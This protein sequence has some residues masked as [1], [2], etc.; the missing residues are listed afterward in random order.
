MKR[1]NRKIERKR[2]RERNKE[3]KKKQ[4]KRERHYMNNNW[5]AMM[6]SG[7]NVHENEDIKREKKESNERD[8]SWEGEREHDG[9]RENKPQRQHE[10]VWYFEH[11]MTLY[12]KWADTDDYTTLIRFHSL[13]LSPPLTISFN[14][15][16]SLIFSLFH[17]SI[18]TLPLTLLTNSVFVHGA[19]LCTFILILFTICMNRERESN[20][21]WMMPWSDIQVRFPFSLSCFSPWRER[22]SFFL[23]HS[24]FTRSAIGYKWF[25]DSGS[26]RMSLRCILSQSGFSLSPFNSVPSFPLL[27][28]FS[29]LYSSLYFF[30]SI[31]GRKVKGEE[32]CFEYRMIVCSYACNMYGQ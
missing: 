14:L 7:P 21:M 32:K 6:M 30:H 19:I 25:P 5:Q 17:I 10:L 29:Y 20:S 26:I 3:R 31:V 18:S 27:S 15:D 13:S 9:R 24:V 11:W 2:N 12:I 22:V 28:S 4:R 16:V 1:E 23:F 8:C